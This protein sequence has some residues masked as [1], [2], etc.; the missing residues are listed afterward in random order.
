MYGR[1]PSDLTVGYVSEQYVTSIF[2]TQDEGTSSSETLVFP[3][4]ITM[5]HNPEDQVINLNVLKTS[6]FKRKVNW[7]LVFLKKRTW[8]QDMVLSDF[9]ILRILK[10]M[11]TFRR[12]L[13]LCRSAKCSSAQRGRYLDS[14]N[15]T[16]FTGSLHL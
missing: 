1:T 11:H 16:C 8:V 13:H 10:I 7:V 3:Y 14:R 15:L 5:C 2:R 6:I 12:Y 4:H 9:A